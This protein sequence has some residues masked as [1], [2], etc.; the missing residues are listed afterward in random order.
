MNLPHHNMTTEPNYFPSASTFMFLLKPSVSDCS[1]PQVQ[2]EQC[3]EDLN[4]CK[5]ETRIAERKLKK[6]FYT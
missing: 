5:V 2:L 4:R 6:G 1:I 3:E